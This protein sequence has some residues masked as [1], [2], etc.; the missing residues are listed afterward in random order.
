MPVGVIIWMQQPY[1]EK[2]YLYI[3]ETKRFRRKKWRRD[4]SS[5]AGIIESWKMGQPIRR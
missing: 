1:Y 3:E 4:V 2:S 5:A